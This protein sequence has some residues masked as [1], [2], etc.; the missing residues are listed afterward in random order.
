VLGQA[1][2]Q[3]LGERR[4]IT[5]FGDAIVPLDEALAL[6]ALD[7]SGRPHADVTIEF[8]REQIGE[9]PTEN[10][11]HL[12]ESFAREGRMTLHVRLL[13]GTNDHHRAEAVFKALARALRAAVSVDTAA[14]GD[15]PSTKDVL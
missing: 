15:V 6:V 14:A 11:W 8:D 1:F 4:G 12:L 13:A 5:R 3:A 10:L 2:D 7:L 9:L